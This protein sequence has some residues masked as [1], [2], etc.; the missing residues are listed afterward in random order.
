MP[1][2]LFIYII[3]AYHDHYLDSEIAMRSASYLLDRCPCRVAWFTILFWYAN[4]FVYKLHISYI[5]IV[6]LCGILHEINSNERI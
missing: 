3:T 6:I 2:I 5:I 4:I 1:L